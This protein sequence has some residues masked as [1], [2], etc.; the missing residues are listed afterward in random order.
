MPHAI[1]PVIFYH[2]TGLQKC[3]QL[4][5]VQAAFL[6]NPACHIADRHD[7]AAFQIQ[8]SGC[9][10][11]D[12]THSLYGNGSFGYRNPLPLQDFLCHQH[13][14]ASGGILSAQGTSDFNRLAGNDSGNGIS[15]EHAVSIHNPAH[16]LRI[17]VDVRRR[18]ILLRTDQGK[19]H[20]GIPS[21]KPF[22]LPMGKLPGVDLHPAFC[23]SVRD[24]DHC[25]FKGHPRR[26]RFH[27]IHVHIFVIADPAF[28]RASGTGV[29]YPVALK[30]PDRSI[31]HLHRNGYLQLPFRIFQYFVIIF[32]Q[33]QQVSRFLHRLQHILIGIVFFTHINYE[34][35][36]F[37]VMA[38]LYRKSL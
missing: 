30:Y 36:H 2:F 38:L 31:V 34:P 26:K 20:S 7:P 6:I 22:E 33:P 32:F 19:N 11:A 10:S 4:F 25:T 8:F 13:D 14:A 1:F 29:L 15:L 27:F 21:R 28:A 35:P 9:G 37:L 18:N 17:G 16:D 23:S 24:I 5:H 3:R 12:I